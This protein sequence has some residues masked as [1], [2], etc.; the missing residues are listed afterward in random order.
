MCA[1]HAARLSRV[2]SRPVRTITLLERL[3]WTMP[4]PG[5]LVSSH[6]LVRIVASP[7]GS[8]IQDVHHNYTLATRSSASFVESTIC[9]SSL[10]LITHSPWALDSFSLSILQR[11]KFKWLSIVCKSKM[12]IDC[13]WHAA[14]EEIIYGQ[15]TQ[16][17]LFVGIISAFKIALTG[18]PAL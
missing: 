4:S 8:S 18:R 14:G 9:L 6:W 17:K 11:N 10:C 16:F 7:G 13:V 2:K 3:D 12:Q 5:I 1:A 15:R